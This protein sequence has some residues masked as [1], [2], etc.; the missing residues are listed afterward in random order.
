MKKVILTI[1]DGVGVSKKTIG[2]A[3]VNAKTP[4]IDF[5]LNN[6]PNSL[7]EASGEYVGLP[8]GQMGNSEVGHMTIGSGRVI[9]QSLEYIN[10]KIIDKSFYNDK[11]ILDTIRHAKKSNGSVHLLGL[12][13]NGGVHSS[14]Y[15][16]F[17]L[18]EILK[19]EEVE[20]SYIH[21]ITDG[22]DTNI[23]SGIKF[24]EI[25]E[26]KIKELGINTRIASVS[27]RFY[28]MDRDNRYERI[29]KCYDVLV[30][31]VKKVDKNIN[32]YIKTS[33]DNGVYDEFIEPVLF[34]K[35][36]IISDNDSVIVYNFRPD[37][38][39]E[40]LTAL[41][42]KSFNEFKTKNINN[43]KV[44][45]MMHVNDNLNVPYV[46]SVEEINNPL[47]VY[48]DKMGISQLRIAETEKYAHVTYFFDG[49]RERVLNN[50]KRI[51]IPSP[52]V[53]TY[54][55]MPEMS[56]YKIND[57]LLEDLKKNSYDLIVLNYAN[58]D[59]VGHTGNYEKAVEAVE[60]VDDALGELYRNLKDEYIFLITADHGNCEVMIN[61]DGSVNTHHT[62]NK[63]FFIVTM[64][65]IE[66]RNG[67]LKDIAPTI[68]DIMGIKREKDMTGKSLIIDKNEL[69]RNKLKKILKYY[70]IDNRLLV[71]NKINS[72]IYRVS[73]ISIDK[74]RKLRYEIALSIGVKVEDLIIKK[75]ECDVDIIKSK[76]DSSIVTY[77]YVD[78]LFKYDKARFMVPIG[79]DYYDSLVMFDFN[80]DKNMFITGSS[81]IGKSNL[82]SLIILNLVKYYGDKKIYV[83]D[84]QG[85]NYKILKD[86]V[87]IYK[88]MD[89]FSNVIDMLYE[90]DMNEDI[91]IVLDE[92]YDL[93]DY[94]PSIC[95][96]I[97]K[98]I[99]SKSNIHFIMSNDTVMDRGVYSVFSNDNGVK[100]S[101]NLTSSLEYDLFL[102]KKIDISL[103]YNMLYKKGNS[104]KRV[105][106][107]MIDDEVIRKNI[108]VG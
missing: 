40:I 6:Y 18:L 43:L 45:S 71:L 62:T 69:F 55:M 33:Y 84:K 24:I 12:L 58:G 21:V 65:G 41:T 54:D 108:S 83:F 25:L 16:L 27:G 97:N 22:R 11:L 46:Y 31:N 102:G 96:K 89:E 99:E 57:A 87:E 51:L 103:G 37:R 10:K 50:G 14:I 79:I 95:S 15:H 32:D 76:I 70:D 105:S 101:F 47:G 42:D 98:I 1:L 8:K 100:V 4:N 34:D 81:G 53:K 73:D 36:G 107:C 13:S 5:L 82:I 59:M 2:N 77:N 88:D 104:I 61:D 60:K 17:S 7:L 75:N 63:V 68:L 39:R 9:Y 90:K 67:S 30:G 20:K 64:D 78:S 35:K 28:A 44:I 91:I 38:L 80:R 56:A 26:D 48:L 3:F 72:V 66:L 106:V 74:I 94:R 23:D 85:V 92:V 19:K 52:K 29:K 93:F 86:Y 49:G